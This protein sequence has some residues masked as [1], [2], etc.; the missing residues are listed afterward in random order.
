MR[1]QN[2]EILP[3]WSCSLSLLCISL[4]C[5]ALVLSVWLT[6]LNQWC[7]WKQIMAC[8]A[9]WDEDVVISMFIHLYEEMCVWHFSQ[10]TLL[11]FCPLICHTPHRVYVCVALVYVITSI[12]RAV[13]L[14]FVLWS[15]ESLI[16]IHKWSL[17]ALPTRAVSLSPGNG[18]TVTEMIRH[19]DTHIQTLL[20]GVMSLS[21]MP[22]CSHMAQKSRYGQHQ[23]GVRK[24]VVDWQMDTKDELCFQRKNETNAPTNVTDGAEVLELVVLLS[25]CP[26]EESFC[27]CQSKREQL[28]MAF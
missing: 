19:W 25:Q 8:A 9:W 13:T 20:L 2:D 21:D 11:I 4:S 24:L 23:A 10:L 17:E 15:V 12:C 27:K 26:F 7:N 18:L 22:R 1:V 3:L 6:W 14:A 16:F 28:L 5:A